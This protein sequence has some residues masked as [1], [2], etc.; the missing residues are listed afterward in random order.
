MG[1]TVVCVGDG[2]H[3]SGSL[4]CFQFGHFRTAAVF[5]WILHRC[6]FFGDNCRLP[7]IFPQLQGLSLTMWVLGCEVMAPTKRSYGVVC[8]GIFWGIG[9]CLTG[10]IA[11][12]VPDWRRFFLVTSLPCL[13][14]ISYYWYSSIFTHNCYS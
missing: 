4:T 8:Q 5:E 2:N 14:L 1:D 13:S 3:R 6:Q 11:Y 12:L 9:Y 7:I 10:V